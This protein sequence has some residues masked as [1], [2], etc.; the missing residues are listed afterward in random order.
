MTITDALSQT[1]SYWYLHVGLIYTSQIDE[2][3]KYTLL[4]S[5]FECVNEISYQPLNVLV[6]PKSG[7]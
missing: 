5:D 7:W 6:R 1:L 2:I 4:M 3:S